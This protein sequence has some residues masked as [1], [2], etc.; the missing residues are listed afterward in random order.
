MKRLELEVCVCVCVCVCFLFGVCLSA[1]K[2]GCM[3][4]FEYILCVPSYSRS[5]KKICTRNK[6]S[7][8]FCRYTM[9]VVTL[10]IISKSVIYHLIS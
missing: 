2:C 5:N 9:T 10:M 6:V 4:A 3:G 1:G 7:D 8:R